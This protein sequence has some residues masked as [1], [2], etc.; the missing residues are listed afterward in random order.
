M[1][2]NAYKSANPNPKTRQQTTTRRKTQQ[3][4]QDTAPA[5]PTEHTQD[6][7][8]KPESESEPESRRTKRSPNPP[9]MKTGRESRVAIGSG[10]KPTQPPPSLE[11]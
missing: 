9:S 8:H 4:T 1:Q 6:T 10:P 2:C 7:G 5:H 3:K 11:Q